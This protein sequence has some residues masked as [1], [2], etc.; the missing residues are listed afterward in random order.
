MSPQPKSRTVVN[1]FI[2]RARSTGKDFNVFAMLE[3]RAI[4]NPTG[5]AS[6]TWVW[7]SIKPGVSVWPCRSTSGSDGA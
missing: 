6:V 7:Q 5:G 2:S 4:S 3:S 1:P